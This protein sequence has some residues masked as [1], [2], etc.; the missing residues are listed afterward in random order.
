MGIATPI[1]APA[2]PDGPVL[3]AAVPALSAA[4]SELFPASFE[5]SPP[6]VFA[7]SAAAGA[8]DVYKRQA[9]GPVLPGARA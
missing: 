8:A 7:V 2:P 6:S 9:D 4:A 1:R 5:F 3:S